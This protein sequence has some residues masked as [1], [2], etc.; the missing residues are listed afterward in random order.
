MPSSLAGRAMDVFS[1]TSEHRKLKNIRSAFPHDDDT[2]NANICDI[3]ADAFVFLRYFLVGVLFKLSTNTILGSPSQGTECSQSIKKI[4]A[5]LILTQIRLKQT[6]Y[7][8]RVLHGMA[9][10][11]SQ[12]VLF[13]I[14]AACTDD[15][16]KL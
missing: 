8:T 15:N 12:H 2:D 6:Y 9:A 3:Y 4:V 16:D 10:P 5:R 1:G 14:M 7:L 13:R 11:D